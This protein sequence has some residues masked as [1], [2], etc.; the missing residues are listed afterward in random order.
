MLYTD[1]VYGQHKIEEE[2]VVELINSKPV[3]RLKK[4]SQYGINHLVLKHLSTTRFEHSVGVYLLLRRLNA[5]LKEQINGLLH[6]VSHTAFSHV[7]DFVFKN[8]EQNYHEKFYNKFLLNSEIP[9]ILKR[10]NLSIDD[11]TA[12]TSHT[13]LE[14]D[15]PDLCADR[16]DYFYRDLTHIHKISIDEA[17]N[18]LGHLII[19]N[20]EILFDDINAA[21]FFAFNYCEGNKTFWA[22]TKIIMFMTMM[23]E[24]IGIALK[25]KIISEGDL[26]LTDDVVLRIIKDSADEEINKRFKWIREDLI[27]KEDE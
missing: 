16:L 17:H 11:V 6:D 19:M 8:S 13:L 25:N 15:F 27:L 5:S 1:K 22:D 20:N 24:I 7:A 10:H 26:F 3:Q 9:M 12:E 21:K 18:N 14:K 23:A 2:V 4:I